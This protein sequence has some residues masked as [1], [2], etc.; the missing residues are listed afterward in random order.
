MPY[1]VWRRRTSQAAFSVSAPEK[2]SPPLT[3]STPIEWGY[4]I[5]YAVMLKEALSRDGGFYK[6]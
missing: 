6:T 3:I 2:G 1:L 4:L 5:A